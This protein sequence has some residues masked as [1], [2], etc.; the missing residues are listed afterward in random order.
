[1]PDLPVYAIVLI[2]LAAVLVI[3]LLYVAVK[4]GDFSLTR[5]AAIAAPPSSVFPHVNDLHKYQEW[6]P[7]ATIDPTS[8]TIYEGPIEGV[9]AKFTW[10]G[11]KTGVGSM[12]IV[13][14]TPSSLIRTKLEFLKPMVATNMVDYIFR[15]EGDLTI[16]TCTMT[17]KNGFMGKL[18]TTFMNM[19]KI[20]GGRFEKGLA[21]LKRIVETA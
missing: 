1:M 17:G 16:V 7:W 8:K 19:D 14:S 12:T 21:N 2:C 10:V 3:F 18:F 4:P 13:E 15:T 5:S 20:V 11:K 6:S 9:G